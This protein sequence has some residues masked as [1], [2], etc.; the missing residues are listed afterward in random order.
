MASN[1]GRGASVCFHWIEPLIEQANVLLPLGLHADGV[2]D[3]TAGVEVCGSRR[4]WD[5]QNR[6]QRGLRGVETMPILLIL[7]EGRQ[8]RSPGV[9]QEDWAV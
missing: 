6:R 1:G 9:R 3:V 8:G 7:R 5:L 2:V 4:M